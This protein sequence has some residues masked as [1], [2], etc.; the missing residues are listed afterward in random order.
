M[1]RDQSAAADRRPPPARSCPDYPDLSLTLPA[2]AENVA[3]VRH[4]IGGLGE[5]LAIDDQT[6]SDVKL[7]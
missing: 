1:P 5:A 6:L 2:R 4:A 7:A 3:V